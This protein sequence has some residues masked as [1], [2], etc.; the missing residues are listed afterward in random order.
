MRRP[1]ADCRSG[2]IPGSRSLPFGNLL[3]EDGKMLPPERLQAA[4]DTAGVGA[5]EQ[6][7]TSCGSGVTA[8]IISLALAQ[9]CGD[10]G[11]I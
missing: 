8:A 2:H 11:E 4:L 6:L 5:A 9:V 3:G 1:R 7:V 10:I